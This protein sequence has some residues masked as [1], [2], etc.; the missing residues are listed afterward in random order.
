[1][2]VVLI[3]VSIYTFFFVLRESK[4]EAEEE[5]RF[6]CLQRCCSSPIMPATQNA[7]CRRPASCSDEHYGAHCF[8]S[9]QTKQAREFGLPDTVRRFLPFQIDAHVQ[10]HNQATRFHGGAKQ[11][12][13]GKNK[14]SS[15]RNYLLISLPG[16][17][18]TDQ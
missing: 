17:N 9:T 5:L 11:H 8:G 6:L 18:D 2:F 4:E 13:T 16:K 1:M 12:T 10:I 14:S 7:H 15:L 3:L